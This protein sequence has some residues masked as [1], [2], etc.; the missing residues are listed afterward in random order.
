MCEPRALT[1]PS[2]AC[3]LAVAMA[4]FVGSTLVHPALAM[5]KRGQ[6]HPQLQVGVAVVNVLSST[7]PTDTHASPR[8]WQTAET[9]SQTLQGTRT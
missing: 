1:T 7:T 6:R 3:V 2:Q 8:A 5:T 4:A 9:A